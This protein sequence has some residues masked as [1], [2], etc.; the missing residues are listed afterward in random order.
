MTESRR[1]SDPRPGG[2][3]AAST[4]SGTNRLHSSYCKPQS[5]A[6][7]L[8]RPLLMFTRAT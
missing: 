3:H 1:G 8:W 5:M 4:S 7:M 6:T 2:G